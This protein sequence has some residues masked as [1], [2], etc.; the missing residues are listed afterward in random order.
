MIIRL[1]II[2]PAITRNDVLV[3]GCGEQFR[4]ER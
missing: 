1:G 4:D 3:L 2:R